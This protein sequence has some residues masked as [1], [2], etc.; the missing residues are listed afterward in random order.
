MIREKTITITAPG[1]DEGAVFVIKEKPAIPASDWFIRVMQILARSGV[2]VP[3]HIMALGPAGFVT[4]SIGAVLTGL[5]KAPW[6][7]VKPLLDELLDCVSA[8]Q[9]AG[10]EVMITN[11]S[12]IRAQIAE[13]AT[14]FQ[15]YEEVVSLHLGF[16]LL[17]RLSTYREMATNLMAALSLNT[18]TSTGPSPSSSEAATPAS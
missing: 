13:P 4:M 3:P 5:G 8:A 2:D 1:R 12:L 14:V 6:G 15:I 17:A 10:G 18:P 11:R 9:P 7:E 16:S